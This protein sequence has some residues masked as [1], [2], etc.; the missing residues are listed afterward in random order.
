MSSF[1]LSVNPCLVDDVQNQIA[2]ELPVVALDGE[3]R[4]EDT[5]VI[6]KILKCCLSIA[7]I[8]KDNIAG[9]YI[10]GSQMLPAHTKQMF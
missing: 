8:H 7:Q 5:N 4:K 2:K 9:K 3:M 10:I 6:S 1:I